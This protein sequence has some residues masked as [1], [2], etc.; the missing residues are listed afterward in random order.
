MDLKRFW[1]SGWCRFLTGIGL[2][3]GL[4]CATPA[5]NQQASANAAADQRSIG[6]NASPV[7]AR[8][9]D[10]A[11]PIKEPTGVLTLR[12]A[13]ALALMEN[14]ELAPFAWQTRAIEA[15]ILQSSLRPNPE[16]GLQVEDIVGTGRFRG[17]REA[18]VTLQLSQVIELGGKRA[19]RMDVASQGRDIARSEY[20]I[21]RVEVLGELTQRFILVVANQHALA[22][23]LTNRDLAK[24]AF[25]TVTERGQAGRVSTLEEQKA[26]LALARAELLVEGAQ[27]EL[28]A[29]RKK[30]SASWKNNEPVFERAEADLFARK[31][32]PPFENL[33]GRIARS[34]E[35][36][37]WISERKLREAEVRLADARRGPNITVG[38]GIRRLE[39]PGD[40]AFVLG[41]SMP[42][43]ISDRQ[44]GVAAEARAL[45]GR[46]EAEQHATK[47][48]LNSVLLGIHEEMEH[49]LHIMEGQQKDILPKAEKAL[50]TARD[51]YSQGRFSYLEV[52]D[53]QRTLFDV[54][55]ELIRAATSYHQFIG[56]MERLIGQPFDQPDSQP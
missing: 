36:Q 30:L 46:S 43:Q 14:P 7:V 22:L 48:R 49:D 38:G 54:H 50:A 31:A 24:D 55:Q 35:I 9:S 4:G 42:L 20:E 12:D 37:R 33:A 29:A 52:L 21:K 41:L 10:S 13:V 56:E 28:R 2:M 27:H 47:F 39:G 1:K 23:A 18:Q 40:Q 45:L 8:P 6:T 16:L 51:G 5:T 34:P 32:I 19:A 25:R 3:I 17:V 11:T 53:A 26:E 44:Q 15:R